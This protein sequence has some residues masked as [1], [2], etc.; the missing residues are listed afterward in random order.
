ME[1]GF[2][3]VAKTTV[4]FVLSAMCNPHFWVARYLQNATVKK[5]MNITLG[6]IGIKHCVI[7]EPYFTVCMSLDTHKHPVTALRAVKTALPFFSFVYF[8]CFSPSWAHKHP[9][10]HKRQYHKVSYRMPE[11]MLLVLIVA[12]KGSGHMM[13]GDAGL[14]CSPCNGIAVHRFGRPFGALEKLSACCYTKSLLGGRLIH[15]TLLT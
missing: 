10:E 6:T 1:N 7:T 8:T 15:F 9:P 4:G 14:C 2:P 11:N 12:N 13:H 5:C 3:Y